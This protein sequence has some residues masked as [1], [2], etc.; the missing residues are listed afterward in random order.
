[1]YA[2]K[3]CAVF[4][5]ELLFLKIILQNLYILLLLRENNNYM[6][7]LDLSWLLELFLYL[8]TFVKVLN[9]RNT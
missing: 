2:V 5:C 6:F 7:F 3:S 1:M 8:F 9:T 4:I